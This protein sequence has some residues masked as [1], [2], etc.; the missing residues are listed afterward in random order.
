MN[1]KDIPRDG[2]KLNLIKDNA[3]FMAMLG[4]RA[5][6]IDSINKELVSNLDMHLENSDVIDIHG[7]VRVDIN[8]KCVRCLNLFHYI[9]D[10]QF[11]V[12]LEPYSNNFQSYHELKKEELDTEFYTNHDFEPENIV[13]EQVMISLSMYPLC[14]PDCKGLCSICGTNLNEHQD[15]VCKKAVEEDNPLRIKLQRLKLIKGAK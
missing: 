9:I 14:K 12:M 11:T 5:V 7:N 2:F 10:K 6:E 1:I 15:H 3:W 13:F 8:M 4:L